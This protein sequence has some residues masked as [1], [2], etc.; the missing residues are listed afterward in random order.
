[1]S[2]P[3]ADAFDVRRV[4]DVDTRGASSPDGWIASLAAMQH[5]V[6]ARRQL[7]R[8]GIGREA[9]QH[10]LETGRLYPL[11]RGIYAVG[12][13]RLSAEGRWSAAVLFAGAGAV[14]GGQSGAVA[15]G[16]LTY[17]PGPIEVIVPRPR[18]AR[19]GLRLRTSMLLSDEV[20]QVRDI[21]VTTPAR[22]LFD[23][24]ATT[25]PQIVKL[26]FDEAEYRRLTSPVGLAVLLQRHPRQPGAAVLR[27]LL[28]RGGRQRTRTEMEVDFGGFCD[29]H[30]LPRPDETNVGRWIHGRYIEADAVYLEPRIIIEL[31]GGSHLTERRFHDDRARDRAN[32]ASGDWRTVRVTSRHLDHERDELAA[33]LD[34]LLRR[35]VHH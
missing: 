30:G 28:A 17:A 19:R 10:R 26:A 34:I 4:R 20:T 29:A 32:L 8:L 6:V 21:P 2:L 35:R 5:G 13:R 25:R 3:S 15:L 23:M 31:D 24:A 18:R 11:D 1:M 9:I 16:M 14:L 7:L 22:T 27:A 12:H 33:D